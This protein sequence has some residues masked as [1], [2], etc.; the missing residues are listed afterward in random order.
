VE[1]IKVSVQGIPSNGGKDIVLLMTKGVSTP[2]DCALHIHEL[3]SKHPIAL[4]NGDT[5]WDFHRPLERDCTLEFQNFLQEDPRKVN[6]SFWKSCSF[7]LGLVVE[8]AFKADQEVSLH[9]WPKHYPSSGSFV[10]DVHLPKLKSWSPTRNELL[11][12]T[13]TLWKIKDKG[14]NFERL[15]V[16]KEIAQE[17]FSNNQFKLQ[18]LNGM[19]RDRITIYRLGEH[20]DI[21]VGPMI[22]SSNRVGRCAVTAVHSVTSKDNVGLYRFQGIAIPDTLRLNAFAYN[23][24]VEKSKEVN[25][26]PCI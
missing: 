17:I 15:D 14:L 11:A 12:L 24:L 10:Y 9:S 23:L 21:S 5:L 7:I 26:A 8:T 25:P 4:V 6:R 3:Y 1:K 19:E 22:S 2:Y 13:S 18:Q 16:P 20:I